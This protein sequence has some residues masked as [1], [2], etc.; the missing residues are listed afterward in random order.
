MDEYL[1]IG[2]MSKLTNV[3][4]QALRHYE[5][6]GLMAPSY[7]NSET[8][9]RYY[10]MK[11][12]VTIGLIKQCKALGLSLN[13]IKEVIY[14]YTSLE[15]IS[16]IL[17]NQKELLNNKISQLQH[18]E[19]QITL[20]ESKIR[21]SLEKGLNEV[22]IKYNEERKCLEFDYTD[23]NTMKFELDLR[24]SLV[25]AEKEYKNANTEIVFTV[26]YEEL[27][28]TNVATYKNV[29]LNLGQDVKYENEKII[30]IPEGNYLTMYFDDAHRNSLKYYKIVMDYISEHNIK[31]KGDF[32]EIYILTRMGIDGVIKSL[33]KIEIL[34]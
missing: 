10:S 20:L 9:Y 29:M 11:D 8:G 14:N 7:I 6:L 5:G 32:R 30:T 34:I 28:K 4:V 31:V 33:G 13:E 25:V 22:F 19:K 12:F 23:R 26:S 18:I 3:S 16:S 17:V 15:S 2:Q 24:K 27:K 21:T 1:T